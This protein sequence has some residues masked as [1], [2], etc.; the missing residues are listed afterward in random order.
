[1]DIE[2]V[3]GFGPL[4]HHGSLHAGQINKSS[5]LKSRSLR[6]FCSRNL[7]EPERSKKDSWTGPPRSTVTV[8]VFADDFLTTAPFK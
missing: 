1:V 4:R 7:P 8:K 5:D 3:P 2:V 6:D